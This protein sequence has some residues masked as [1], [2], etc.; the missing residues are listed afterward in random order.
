MYKINSDKHTHKTNIL[1]TYYIF[2]RT[3]RSQN[4]SWGGIFLSMRTFA[5]ITLLPS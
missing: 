4:I 1:V 2:F 3:F 5:L